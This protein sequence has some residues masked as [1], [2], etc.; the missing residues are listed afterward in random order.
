MDL[1]TR[2]GLTATGEWK[3]ISHASTSEVL[4]LRAVLLE[5][6]VDRRAEFV[7]LFRARGRLAERVTLNAA[8]ADSNGG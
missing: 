7:R 4:H 5:A 6:R 2:A 3:P 8:L 1:L